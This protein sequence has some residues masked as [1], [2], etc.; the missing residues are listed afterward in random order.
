VRMF[1]FDRHEQ[2]SYGAT[3]CCEYWGMRRTSTL[4]WARERRCLLVKSG[5]KPCVLSSAHGKQAEVETARYVFFFRPVELRA[6]FR[7]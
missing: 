2:A 1:N 4:C 6:D 7:E 3:S 5:R